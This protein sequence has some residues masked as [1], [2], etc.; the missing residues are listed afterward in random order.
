MGYHVP[1]AFSVAIFAYM[2]LVVFRPIA[3]GSWSYGFPYGFMSHLDWVSGTGYTYGNF[4]YNPAHMIAISFFFTTCLALALHGAL[5]LSSV[6]PKKGEVVKT[7]GARKHL[8]PRHDR[9]LHRHAGHPSPR[10]VPG[11]VGRLLERGMHHHQRTVVGRGRSLGRLVGLVARTADLVVRGE[12]QNDLLPE[13]LY[14][15]SR[16]LPTRNP[17]FLC[18][19]TTPSAAVRRGSPTGR[20][21][22]VTLKSVRSTSERWA[23][24]PSSVVSSHSRSSASICWRR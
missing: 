21:R 6:N 19:R 23:S 1:F 11:A 9:L 18:R 16:C 14:S 5:V 17:A 4:H 7:A 13:H 20:A 8:L 12:Q 2:T 15:A 24:S 22:L 10:L 3:M